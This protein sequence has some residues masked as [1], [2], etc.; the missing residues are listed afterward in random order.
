M[1][2]PVAATK[3]CGKC[4]VEKNLADFYRN[5][6]K[7]DGHTWQCKECARAYQAARNAQLRAE[8]G[9]A[10]YRALRNGQ[11]R[12]WRR[13]N[14]ESAAKHQRPRHTAIRHLIEAH[15]DE[16]ER[17]LLLAKRGEIS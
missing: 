7:K 15:R 13:D 12:A 3:V 1:S 9:D 14:P 2:A 17:L 16:Y 10:A 11:T 4:G 5:N 6:R 8:M